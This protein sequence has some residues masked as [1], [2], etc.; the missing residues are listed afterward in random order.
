MH[1]LFMSV[2]IGRAKKFFPAMRAAGS[3]AFVDPFDMNSKIAQIGERFVTLTALVPRP[4]IIVHG[5]DVIQ[6][7]TPPVEYHSTRDDRA[8]QFH[9][10]VLGQNVSFEPRLGLEYLATMFTLE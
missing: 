9:F 4:I 8:F 5:S 1:L 10:E 7:H 2:S 6:Q 3:F